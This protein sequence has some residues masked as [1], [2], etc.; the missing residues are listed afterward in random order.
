MS[1]LLWAS[2]AGGLGGGARYTVDTIV[3]GKHRAGKFAAGLP[4]GTL[5]VNV[6]A[7]LLMGFLTGFVGGRGD[8]QEWQIILGGGFL[9]GYSTF[10]TASVEAAKL[11]GKR[12]SGAALAHALGMAFSSML[13]IL[14]GIWVGASI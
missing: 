13:A 9:G 11:W 14:I 4:L 8:W 2:L 10:S 12:R 3:T 6:T 1:E 7:C 5:I